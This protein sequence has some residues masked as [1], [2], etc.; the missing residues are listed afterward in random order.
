M[1]AIYRERAGTL[2]DCLRSHLDGDFLVPDVTAG[3][4]LTI[5]SHGAIDDRA[6][7]RRLLDH[8][9]DCPPLSRYCRSAL[10]RHGFVLGF[11]NNPVKRI[12]RYAEILARTIEELG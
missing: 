4:H 11:G 8:E 2:A 7:S 6:V 3:L 9:M 12:R 1:R 5:R 10:Q